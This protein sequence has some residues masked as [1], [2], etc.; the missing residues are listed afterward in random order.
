L[1]RSLKKN[2]L[3][4]QPAIPIDDNE[5][6]HQ[7]AE[8][9]SPPPHLPLC[10]LIA[11][12]FPVALAS[13][14]FDAAL[15]QLQARIGYDFRAPDLLRRARLLLPRERPRARRPRPCRLPVRRRAP[16]ARQRLRRRGPRSAGRAASEAVCAEAGDRVGIPA[17]VRVA[18]GT[19]AS[20]G[21][22]VC[23]A[24]RALVGAVAVDAG[25]SDAASKVYWKLHD[26]TTA[27]A[28]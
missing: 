21:P 11:I 14:P 4:I 15:S 28:V 12:G 27:A 19:N 7:A 17:I 20:A 9:A 16:R 2:T 10:V 22:V 23:G 5:T 13:S 26:V 18:A 3:P 25:S 8:M 1:H 24:L 6:A